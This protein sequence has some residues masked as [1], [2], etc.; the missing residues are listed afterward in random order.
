MLKNWDIYGTL[1]HIIFG[2]RREVETSDNWLTFGGS[3]AFDRKGRKTWDLVY[4][5]GVDSFFIIPAVK[6]VNSRL[7]ITFF[8][9]LHTVSL[10]F[11]SNP[12]WDVHVWKKSHQEFCT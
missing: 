12:W 1:Y 10:K 7:G 5:L 9:N 2:K 8:D 4:K 11:F 3:H 6:I